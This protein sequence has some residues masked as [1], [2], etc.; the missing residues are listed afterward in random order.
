MTGQPGSGETNNRTEVQEDSTAANPL[1]D[2]QNILG[3]LVAG[4]AGVLS[5]LGIR[6][7]E[8]SAVLRNPSTEGAASFIMLILFLAAFA[9]VSGVTLSRAK[10]MSPWWVLPIVL[11]L[12]GTGLILIRATPVNAA[13]Q[14][15]RETGLHIGVV[16]IA[17]AGVSAIAITITFIRKSKNESS[18]VVFPGGEI[19]AE[20]QNENS[21]AGVE[22]GGIHA[23]IV[24]ILVSLTLLGFGIYGAT[25]LEASSQRMASVQ[26]SASIAKKASDADLSVHVTGSKLENIRYVGVS[27]RG[28]PRKTHLMRTCH[29]N[30]QK[31]YD[32][33]LDNPCQYVPSTCQLIYGAA[34]PANANGELNYTLSDG[35]IPDDYRDI[36]VQAF[37]CNQGAGCTAGT[38]ATSELDIHVSKPSTRMSSPS[39][40]P[41]G[42]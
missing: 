31:S 10:E 12:I 30:D 35:L 38:K 32:N 37:I 34:V 29:K 14:G 42:R 24:C 25:R 1:K 4:F 22:G 18:S 11:G 19:H 9:A 8:V 23:E 28:V 7:G 33:C 5:F 2:V 40:S 20:L 15:L 41:K 17:L 13:Q 16:L 6:S 21:S 26:L 36:S 39:S 3:F 27:I